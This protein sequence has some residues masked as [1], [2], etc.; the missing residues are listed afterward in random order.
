MGNV[1]QQIMLRWMES[2]P[3]LP[4]EAVLLGLGLWLAVCTPYST[5]SA[6]HTASF[7]WMT[8]RSSSCRPQPTQLNSDELTVANSQSYRGPAPMN[9]TDQCLI[10]SAMKHWMPTIGLPMQLT[11]PD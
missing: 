3:T 10:I 1:T 9:F 11:C 8:C 6:A 4:W 7:Q 2:V 5:S